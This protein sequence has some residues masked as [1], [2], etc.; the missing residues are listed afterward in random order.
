MVRT[1]A[2]PWGL[3]WVTPA[4]WW[5]KAGSVTLRDQGTSTAAR[6]SRETWTGPG[7]WSALRRGLWLLGNTFQK[8]RR[9]F[10]EEERKVSVFENGFWGVDLQSSPQCSAT[11]TDG[12]DVVGEAR[13]QSQVTR[14]PPSHVQ[15]RA[16]AQDQ[17]EPRKRWVCIA[18]R[19]WLVYPPKRG[20]SL[21][22]PERFLR[23]AQGSAAGRCLFRWG[24]RSELRKSLCRVCAERP[25]GL[26][27]SGDLQGGGRVPARPQT[28]AGGASLACCLRHGRRLPSGRSTGSGRL[29]P[30]FRFSLLPPVRTVQRGHDPHGGVQHAQD[31]QGE[32]DH[33]G[34]GEGGGGWEQGASGGHGSGGWRLGGKRFWL[35]ARC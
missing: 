13:A 6:V 35:P 33:Q 3:R 14:G 7:V 10:T 12:V 30:L 21:E 22:T 4:P 9:Q 19:G 17:G 2:S 31:H 23:P 29:S 1:P 27:V 32:C 26:L 28:P 24:S 25:S 15:G 8:S 11:L 34:S 20:A 16:D 18:F 5:R